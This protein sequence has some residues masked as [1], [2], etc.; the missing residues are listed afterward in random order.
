MTHMPTL[1]DLTVGT[2]ARS[3]C[4]TVLPVFATTALPRADYALGTDAVA[5]GKLEICELP[6]GAAVDHLQARN[7]G[8][9]RVLLVEGDHLIGARQNRMLT[10]SVL[11]GGKREVELPVSCVEQGRWRASS[12]QFAADASSGSPRLRQIAKLTV[13]RSL[14]ANRERTVDQ[15]QIW[16]QI[17]AQQRSLH[18]TSATSA[19]SHTYAARASDISQVAS[20]LP[21][22]P[23]AIGVALGI[24]TQ[25]VSID[26]FDSPE[27]CQ[28]YWRR[29]VEGA[30]LE[31]LGAP[32]QPAGLVNAEVFRLLDELRR[33]D[34][35]RVPAVGDG[36][37]LRTSSASGAASLLLLDGRVVHFGAATG[38]AAGAAAAAALQS[39]VAVMRHDLPASLA[40]RFRVVARIGIGGTKEVFRAVDQQGGPD[41]AIAR[42]PGVDRA[43]FA[44]E[45][46]L[47]QRVQSE[48]VPRIFE[49]VVDDYGDAYLVMERCDGPSLAQ[50]VGNGPL[51]IAD[52]AP[53][54]V[55]FARGLRAIHTACVLHR[56][57]K[58]E[59]VMLCSSDTGPKLK[60]L[61]FGLS[62]RATSEI[63]AVFD[64]SA[65]RIGGTL[66]YMAPE[67]AL[68]DELDARSDVFA[69]GVSC[70]R[71]L[72][73]EL[74][75]PPLARESE[76]QYL[77]RIQH[78]VIDVSR[79]P[80]ALPP[81]V[82]A[83][84]VRMLDPV[85][86]RR[87]FMPE[88]VAAFEHA[89]GAPPIAVATPA[90]SPGRR[91]DLARARTLPIRLASP[92]HLLIAACRHAPVIALSPDASGT[93]EIRALGPDGATRWTRRLAG[94]FSTGLRADLDGDGVRE[95]Y[96]AGPHG[97]AALE[98]TGDVRF[99]RATT[100]PAARPSMVALTDQTW[101][102]LAIDGQTFD[103]RTGDAR[104]AVAFAYHGDG[105]KLV[106]ATDL[107]GLAYNGH[108]LQA[109]CGDQGTGAA[110]VH[111]PGGSRFLVA[112]LEETRSGR[113]QVGIYG[114]GG[115]RL[116]NL[117]V[118][119]CALATGD[120]T[121]ISRVYA[122]P[123]P[124]FGP[125]HAPIALL[126]DGAAAVVIVPLFDPD[127]RVPDSLVA[128]AL[129][130]GRELWRCRPSAPGARAVLADLHGDR[131]PQLVVGTGSAL[132]VHD[133]WTGHASAPL[134]CPGV[135]V[136]FGDP[137]ATGF[138][139]LI[140]ASADGLELWRGPRCQPGAMAWTGARGDLWRTGTLRSDGLPLGPV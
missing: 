29:L 95:I 131:K 139:H 107:A 138:A 55:A 46:A 106:P 121:E 117:V 25:L 56:D 65:I 28:A 115:V 41:V 54:L 133:P 81:P 23:G 30:A 6:R 44:D 126:G 40:A 63:S 9:R 118:S 70:F 111:H 19:L 60:I 87:P 16:S 61:D 124:L 17:S 130:S 89:F 136:G 85:R 27:T 37:E 71:I 128:F 116:H 34:W 140:T 57:I 135:P 10:S 45:I 36:D 96:L 69:F 2:A 84:L 31:G 15:S 97:V 48:Y 110:I 101:P 12:A 32:R 21:Y 4:V 137:F 24:G 90:A 134:P 98:A 7:R 99:A 64:L 51:A 91:L 22:R 123:S 103:A 59:N 67:V 113:V 108:A 43:Q 26:L 75:T 39:Q 35:S 11:I 13:T 72:T 104:G 109:F 80:Q 66:P 77:Q 79:I 105:R 73:G 52:A 82:R 53:I 33:A 94:S 49:A 76:L 20:Q 92:D 78:T 14:L 86:D 42:I 132:V 100:L 5:A 47:A 127:H 119:E 88:V 120:L 18:V 8:P 38:I 74:P 83:M 62:A 93:T 102:Q 68:G 112:H 58:L 3:G 114:L 50:I 125:Q 129:P 122:R 1:P